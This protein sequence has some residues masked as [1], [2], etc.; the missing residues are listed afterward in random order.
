MKPT[1]L[2][3]YSLLHRGTLALSQVEANGIRI[4]VDYLTEARSRTQR[5]VLELEE[6]LRQSDAWKLWRK[7]FGAKANLR[8]RSQLGD[9]LF[10]DLKFT[11]T[12][13]TK[14]GK[15]KVDE[16][17]LGSIDFPFVQSYLRMEKLK[18]ADAT[19]LS[20][21]EQ[22]TV[23]GFLHAM[24]DL[25]TARTFRSSSS[26]P[27]F[28]NFPI[29][30]P[31]LGK[32][33]RRCFVPRPGRVLVEID[34]GSIEVRVAA[35]Y[36]KDPVMLEYIHD[37]SKDM[38][39]DMASQI[40]CCEPG[41]VSKKMRYAAKNQFVFPQFY[42]SYWAQCA[43]ALW[44][45]IAKFSLAVDDKIPVKRWLR[46]HGIKRLGEVPNH[47]DPCKGTFYR[48]V[49][50][51]ERDFWGRRFRVYDQWKKDWYSAYLR[52][53]GFTSLTGFRIDG[54]MS[55]ND[56]INYGIQGSAF[57]CLLWSLIRLQREIRRRKMKT[58][59]VGQIHD[60]LLADVPEDEL[61]DWLA[62]AK[63]VMT[64]EI[65]REWGWIIVPLTIEA[66]VGRRSWHDKKPVEIGA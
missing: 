60:S 23:N 41:Q 49:Q 9:V 24:F 10:K 21:I 7:R 56:V 14:G 37:T 18:K 19:F 52:D 17:V 43:P 3:A 29:R 30:D 62:L 66:E 59:I 36:H 22:E 38:H 2:D 50:E 13:Q 39:R 44:D 15:P 26:R 51:V 35:C 40:Y 54:M 32:L 25:N 42:G 4:D 47:G 6:E 1:T 58:K 27:N 28:Q 5:K 16:D 46:D 64:E 57:H 12:K 34:Y 65:R 63:E 8:S 45:F 20:G 11:S 48:H 55:R 33:I 31:E 61:D 53:G